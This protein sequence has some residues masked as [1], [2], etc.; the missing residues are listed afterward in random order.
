MDQKFF[1]AENEVDEFLAKNGVEGNTIIQ[2]LIFDKEVFKDKD[3][4]R[5]WVDQHG[6]VVHKEIEDN[7]KA[8]R[9]R[10]VDP[11]EFQEDSFKTIEIRRGVKAVVGKIKEVDSRAEYTLSLRADDTINFSEHMPHI[12]E[13][14]KVIE[15]VHPQY[16]VVKI[17]KED[18]KSMLRNFSEGVTGVDLSI[19][20]DHEKR[21]A[22]GWI[23]DL[24]L[25]FEEDVLLASVY[26]CPDGAKALAD[27]SFRY[28]SPEFRFNYVHPHTGEEHGPTLLG[29]ALV[30]HPFLKMGAIVD[31]SNKS[32]GNMSEK[33]IELKVHENKVTE[34]NNKV[35]A[36]ELSEE[37]SKKVIDG[38]KEEI[39]N[40]SDKVKK[41]EDEKTEE[42]R[43][44]KLDK[45][46]SE[47]KI[48]KAQLDVLKKEPSKDILDVLELNDKMNTELKGKGGANGVAIEL[49]ED[50]K[51]W[52]KA[53]DMTEEEFIKYNS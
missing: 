19:N 39:K 28:F 29:G 37:K 17:T 35:T 45:L 32:E 3:E 47:N 22:V 12:I 33:T 16:G 42:A 24:F 44:A 30:N 36:L 23:K 11:S 8:F 50:E 9:V 25:N 34:L 10:Q 27:K 46:F 31:L 20:F 48:N 40:L 13:V 5:E 7:E 6:F 21:E 14:A 41:L 53:N 52:C 18:L 38:Q 51:K 26:W 2:T 49:S 4:V 1:S 15:G 43:V